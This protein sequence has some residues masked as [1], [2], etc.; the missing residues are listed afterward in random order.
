MHKVRN[1]GHQRQVIAAEAGGVLPSFVILVETRDGDAV[2]VAVLG[3]VLPNSGLDPAKP[4]FVNRLLFGHGMPSFLKMPDMEDVQEQTHL[5]AG[6]NRRPNGTSDPQAA[7]TAPAAS[8]GS[9]WN[10]CHD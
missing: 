8:G 2:H 3:L 1:L 6:P 4:D 9:P 7:V 10:A 5:T